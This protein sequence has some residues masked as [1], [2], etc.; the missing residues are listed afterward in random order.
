MLWR[1]FTN[2]F[3]K[4]ELTKILQDKHSIKDVWIAKAFAGNDRFIQQIIHK[5]FPDQMK[6]DEDVTLKL[7]V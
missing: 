3:T 7:D 4:E 1:V 6:I 2:K 5:L